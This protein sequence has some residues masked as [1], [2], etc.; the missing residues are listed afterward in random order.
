MLFRSRIDLVV[1]LNGLAIMSFELKCNAAGQSYQDAIY[2]Y[3]TERNPKTRLFLFKAGCLVNFAMDLNEVYMTTKLADEATYFLPFNIGNG[4]GVDMGAGNPTF[5]DKYS[6][7]YMWEDILKKDT[8]LDLIKR[9][10][11]RRWR[12]SPGRCRSEGRQIGRASCR[13][14]V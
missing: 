6:V 8:V 1:F 3:R 4:N 12:T 13:E 7:S 2:Q 14:R 11:W 10:M 9:F 5:D